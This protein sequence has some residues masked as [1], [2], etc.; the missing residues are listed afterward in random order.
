MIKFQ[1]HP[2]YLKKKKAPAAPPADPTSSMPTP[3]PARAPVHR[4]KRGGGGDGGQIPKH[5]NGFFQ[6]S[7]FV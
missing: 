6:G 1:P 5:M 3:S 7:V 4:G 2:L